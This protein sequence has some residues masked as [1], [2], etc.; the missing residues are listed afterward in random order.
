MEKLKRIHEVTHPAREAGAMREPEYEDD[1]DVA[2]A[3]TLLA[4]LETEAGEDE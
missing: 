4:E 1:A 2:A 3:G